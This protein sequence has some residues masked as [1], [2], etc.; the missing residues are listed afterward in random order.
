MTYHTR[1]AEY[2]ANCPEVG[3]KEY[4]QIHDLA[5][6]L[7]IYLVM[8]AVERHGG[9]LYISQWIFGPLGLIANRRKLKPTA[10]ER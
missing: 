1:I 5:V 2:T 10:V 6:E 3:G 9:S 8:G 4:R 7:G